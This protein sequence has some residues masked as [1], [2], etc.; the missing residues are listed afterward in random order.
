MIIPNIEMKNQFKIEH[1]QETK[2]GVISKDYFV[3]TCLQE[4]GW[5]RETLTFTAKEFED[6]KKTVV[7]Y[8][9]K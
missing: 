8:N 2:E 1:I 7:E 6:F 5:Y 4:S 3:L 9:P